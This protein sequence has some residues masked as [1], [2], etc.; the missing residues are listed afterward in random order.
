LIYDGQVNIANVNLS[1][2][3]YSGNLREV[4]VSL[5]WISGSVQ[6]SREMRTLVSRYGLQNYIY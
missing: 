6:R 3:S 1:G 4:T 5:S 2:T